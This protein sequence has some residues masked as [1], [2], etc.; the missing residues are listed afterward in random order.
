MITLCSNGVSEILGN[1]SKDGELA[2]GWTKSLNTGSAV[3]DACVLPTQSLSQNPDNHCGWQNWITKKATTFIIQQC[4]H[5]RKQ[6][7]NFYFLLG[8]TVNDVESRNQR[9]G[10][11]ALAETVG[12]R[13]SLKRILVI[14]MWNVRG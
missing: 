9:W 11:P 1:Y 10:V 4:P 7:L 2:S 3:P 12:R 14:M 13:E 6:L 5:W 8:T